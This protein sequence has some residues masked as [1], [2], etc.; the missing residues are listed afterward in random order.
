M[1]GGRPVAVK[2][3]GVL[4]PVTVKVNGWPTN[5]TAVRALVTAAGVFVGNTPAGA[6]KLLEA[7]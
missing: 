6:V 2:S 5:A 3:S 4:A 1:P 7:G